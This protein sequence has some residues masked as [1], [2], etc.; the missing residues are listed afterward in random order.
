MTE[1]RNVKCPDCG[2]EF[3]ID[4]LGKNQMAFITC[5]KCFDGPT[6]E[7]ITKN[8]AEMLATVVE[9]YCSSIPGLFVKPET[10]A[11]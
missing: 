7:D 6:L 5:P 11:S 2:C 9:N 3:E 4:K 8:A 10:D 1:K